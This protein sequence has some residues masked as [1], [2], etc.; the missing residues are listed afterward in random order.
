MAITAHDDSS[1]ATSQAAT[2]N[3]TRSRMQR[4]RRHS[5]SVRALRTVLPLCFVVMLFGFGSTVMKTGGFGSGLPDIPIPRILPENLA[6]ANPHYEGFSKDG[7]SY[8]V[9]AKSARQNLS[10]TNIIKLSEI[11]GTL[12]DLEKAKTNFTAVRGD[13]NQKTAKLELFEQINVDGETGLKA[14][15]KSATIDTRDSSLVS[16]EPVNIVFAAGTITANT[17]KFRNKLHEAT[18]FGNVVAQF[19]PPPKKTDSVAEV[20]GAAFAKVA[21]QTAELFAAGDAPLDITSHR[22]D[23]KDAK[24]TA[25]FTG[26]VKAIQSG[27]TLSSPELTV[28]YARDENPD[29]ANK[30]AALGAAAGKVQR[31]AAKGPVVLE[32]GEGD[33]INANALEFDAASNIA[34]LIGNVIMRSGADRHA[35]SE[36]ADLNQTDGTILLAGPSVDVQ[37][38]LN[39]LHGR[40]LFIN[41]ITGAAQLTSP[42]TA[43]SGPGRISA[44]LYSGGAQANQG[45]KPK[46]QAKPD[47]DSSSSMASFKSDPSKPVEIDAEL[48]DVNNAAKTA[49][50]RGDVVAVQGDITIKTSEMIA[51]YTGD[52]NLAEATDAAKS[53]ANAKKAQTELTRIE[54][55]KN[56]TVTSKDGQSVQG[57]WA[58]FDAKANT[59]VVGGEV[60][61]SKGG[62]M[63]RGSRMNI[64]LNT[65]ENTIETAPGQTVQLPGGGGW[66]TT[67]PQSGEA[68]AINRGRPSAVFFPSDMQGANDRKGKKVQSKKNDPPNTTAAPQTGDAWSAQTAPADVDTV[69]NPLEAPE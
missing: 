30:T 34:S 46:A 27:Q 26:N 64:D 35:T 55:K 15:L 51:V 45:K 22:L 1:A 59:V 67:A 23:I 61:L 63:V 50:F 8:K 39:E 25:I 48:L 5:R 62:S 33:R 31:I 17:L 52:I 49:T 58:T 16:K 53:G 37:Q 28:V 21:S 54:A 65:G 47:E 43:G 12:V 6:M 69:P 19:T 10:D 57:D 3:S 56:V 4:A 20:T 32:R 29:A 42:P 7:S 18:F 40:R 68:A 2:A 38:G 66:S 13:Y 44:K 14:V 60:I 9:A 41:R 24:N 36:R 11:T